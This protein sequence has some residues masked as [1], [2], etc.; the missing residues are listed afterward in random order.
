MHTVRITQQTVAQRKNV[1]VGDVLTLPPSEARL[2]VRAGKAVHCGG[3][4]QPQAAPAKS[5]KSRKAKS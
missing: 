4:V 1:R 5:T 2:L 3:V